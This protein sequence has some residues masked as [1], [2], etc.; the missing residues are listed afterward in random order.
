L[1]LAKDEN[2]TI[3]TS[4]VFSDNLC[5]I[6]ISTVMFMVMVMVMCLGICESQELLDDF[7]DGDY[8]LIAGHEIDGVEDRLPR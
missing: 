8:V 7:D 5:I 6:V 1:L 2:K 3:F 4:F